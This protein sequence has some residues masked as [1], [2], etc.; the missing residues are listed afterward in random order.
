MARGYDSRWNGGMAAVWDLL[1]R[2]PPFRKERGKDGAPTFYVILDCRLNGWAT[3]QDPRTG[4]DDG[5]VSRRRG[6]SDS[7]GRWVRDSR[8]RAGCARHA[9]IPGVESARVDDGACGRIAVCQYPV[10]H[11]AK[12][13]WRGWTSCEHARVDEGRRSHYARRVVNGVLSLAAGLCVRRQ[14]EKGTP[15]G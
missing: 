15:A 14:G 6:Q 9:R 7:R 10:Q 8:P 4:N 11:L 1:Y 5:R 3:C 2:L 12:V 13:H